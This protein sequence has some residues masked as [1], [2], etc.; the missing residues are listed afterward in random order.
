MNLRSYYPDFVAVEQSGVHWLL[1]TK[2]QETPEVQ[3][4]DEAARRWCEDATA[5]I[6]THWRYMKVPQKHFEQ[7]QPATLTDLVVTT[8]RPDAE[9]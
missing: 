7:L 1:E 4:K 5:L 6:G 8:D 9:K 3:R 2:G